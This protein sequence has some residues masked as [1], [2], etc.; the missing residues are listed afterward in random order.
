VTRTV[1]DAGS[2]HPAGETGATRR[3]H[4]P[5][6]VRTTDQI[7]ATL[8]TGTANRINHSVDTCQPLELPDR[9]L[10]VPPYA[11]GVWL[12]RGYPS[13][14]R[15]GQVDPEVVAHLEATGLVAQRS[16]PRGHTLA[17]P[18]PGPVRSLTPR[19]HDLGVLSRKRIPTD[20]LRAGQRQRRDLLAGVLD[21]GG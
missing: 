18:G 7:R 13:T 10:P 17:L 4:G 2:T 14:S 5:A 11:L 15:I 12:S 6:R 20:Y 3:R 16:G 9:D 21:A 1:T 19:L 8:R